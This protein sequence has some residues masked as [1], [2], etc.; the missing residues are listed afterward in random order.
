MSPQ[1]VELEARDADAGTRL[2]KFLAEH[3]PG[4]GRHKASELCAKGL[5]RVDG[6]RAKKSTLLTLG[7]KVT[8]ELD[9]LQAL[10]PEP[11]LALEVR[12][13]RDEFVVVNKPAGMPSAP[14]DT[15]ERGSLCGA[16]LARY[17]EMQG[18]G[19]RAREPGIVHRLDTQTSGLVLAARTLDGFQR[20]TRALE[21]EALHKRYLAVVSA[22]GLPESGVISGALAPDAAHPERVRV[23]ADGDRAGYARHK[24][25][26]YRVERVAFGRA[27]VELEVGSAFRHQ[28]RAHLAS[29]GHPIAGDAVYGGEPVAELGARHALHASQISWAGDAT[30]AGFTVNEPLPPDLAQL[31]GA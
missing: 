14:L 10:E 23:L 18:I 8:L 17:P 26:R 12:L 9:E 5:V 25:T 11:E 2:D 22:A 24:L 13:E 21:L 15:S 27:L 4:V 29:I 19:Y 20:L 7:A 1:H 30:L 28:I 16:L 3:V 31:L 6:Q